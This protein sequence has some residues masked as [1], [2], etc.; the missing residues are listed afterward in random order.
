MGRTARAA[1]GC[2]WRMRMADAARGLSARRLRGFAHDARSLLRLHALLCVLLLPACE[3]FDVEPT[4]NTAPQAVGEDYVLVEGQ[5]LSIAAPGVL[6][7]DEDGDGNIL[8]ATLVSAPANGSVYLRPDGAFVYTPDGNCTTS[9]SF[10]YA[11]TDGRAPSLEA[12]VS[13]Q[14]TLTSCV[15]DGACI[16][17]GAVNAENPCEVCDSEAN[18]TAWSAVVAGTACGTCMACNGAGDCN[19][20]PVDDDACPPVDCDVYDSECRNFEDEAAARCASLGQCKQA[21]ALTCSVFSDLAL[22]AA[23]GDGPCMTCDGAGACNAVPSDDSA[24]PA[25]ECDSFDSACRDYN[26]LA[27]SRCNGFG[28]CK[29]A[30]AL[31]CSQY[32]DAQVGVAC[33]DGPCMTC[34][35]AGSCSAT[36]VDDPACPAIDCDV[37]DTTCRDYQDITGQRCAA[38][39]ECK[40]ASVEQCTAFANAPA[41]ILCGDGACMACDGDGECAMTPVDD[42][43]CGVID[44]DHLDAP[45]CT[46]YHDITSARCVD[47]GTCKPDDN[48]SCT[49][50]TYAGTETSCGMCFV[51]DGAS[52]CVPQA[53]GD[54]LFDECN[55]TGCSQS[56][57]GWDVNSSCRVYA[58]TNATRNGGCNGAGACFVVTEIC[59]GAGAQS[60]TAACGVAACK[61]SCTAGDANASRDTVGEVCWQSDQHNCTQGWQC[62]ASGGC[63]H[64]CEDPGNCGADAA[65]DYYSCE[66]YSLSGSCPFLYVWDGTEQRFQTDLNG[67]GKLATKSAKGYFVP[68][69]HDYYVLASAP[70]ARDG[71]LDLRLV[72]ERSEVDYL[73]LVELYAL[74]VPEDV[75]LFAEKLG[76]GSFSGSLASVLHTTAQDLTAL[77]SARHINTGLDVSAKLASSDNDYVVLNANRNVDF[78]YQ[79]LERDL[80]DLAGAPQIKLVIDGQS[81]FPTLPAGTARA[82]T[83]GPRTKLEVDDGTGRFVAVP[84][85]IVELPRL[86]E[87]RRVFVLDVSEAFVTDVYRLRLT[88]LFKTYVD[89]IRIDTS[90]DAAVAPQV[91]P[92]HSVELAYRGF[93]TRTAGEL[94]EYV[95]DTVAPDA[96]SYFPGAY[97]RYGDVTELLTAVDDKF[98]IYFGADELRFR[99]APPA[100]PAPG[101]VRRYV[102]H[103]RAYY[104]DLKVDVPHTVAPLPFAA[105]SNFP[106]ADPEHYPTDS[107]HTDYLASWNTRVE[108]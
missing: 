100:P 90:L 87:F 44:C 23:C 75:Q 72:E 106:Y 18:A 50:V 41:N 38:F 40:E 97:T 102:W 94:Y 7:N 25:V 21:S 59:S 85:S 27:T 26:D 77:V 15:I 80:G 104:K 81:A 108:P 36:P 16:A 2:G 3:G 10:T 91:V 74:D 89:S 48:S 51:C 65:W 14:I 12:N 99:F 63:A 46:N 47:F 67:P 62:D 8:S 60:G 4:I 56:L 1:R 33:G 55:A 88:F 95:Y 79:T 57:Y 64:T 105:M 37:F 66:C 42:S 98:V 19:S 78:T 92:V 17:N 34:N 43:R 20:T 22:G 39:A 5:T 53:P 76:F 58:E 49:D 68:N 32:V 70:V 9:D 107:A 71:V 82:S 30:S 69:A 86:P 93:S 28:E 45:P 52:G 31:N 61:R 54:D 96:P 73:D 24:C 84:T 101:T 13:I 29:A 83:F 11:A 103:S 35:G 6:A